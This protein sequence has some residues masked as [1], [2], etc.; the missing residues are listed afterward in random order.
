MASP[1]AGCLYTRPDLRSPDGDQYGNSPPY[2]TWAAGP[3]A[4]TLTNPAADLDFDNGGLDTGI[5]WVV[6]GDPTA[7]GDDAG[8]A[9]TLNNTDPT[10][11]KF[12]F[13][14][15]D[16]AAAVPKTAIR[17]EY[18]T[19]LATWRNTI[20]HGVADGVIVVD[21]TDLGGGF[22]QV[23]VSIPKTLAVVGK[24][25]ARLDVIVTR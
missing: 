13:K 4:G 20:N 25:F 7:G 16:A 23:T 5:E 14:R 12:V 8:N 3:F 24:L 10:Y 2:D 1:R 15:R 11:F 9:P 17:V 6:G 18:G 19:D 22:H 21:T